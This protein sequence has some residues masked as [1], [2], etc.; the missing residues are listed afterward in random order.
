MAYTVLTFIKNFKFEA[1]S[2]LYNFLFARVAN[3][4]ISYK[5]KY[6]QR[7]MTTVNVNICHPFKNAYDNKTDDTVTECNN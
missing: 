5:N 4:L 6:S 1:V 7:W 3:V 2:L